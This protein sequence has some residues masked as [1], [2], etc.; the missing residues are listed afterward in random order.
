[1][2]AFVTAELTPEALDR[3]KVIC[4]G[5]VEVESW[6]ETKNLYFDEDQLI[7]RLKGIDIFICEG[8][9]VKT[10]VIEESTSLKIIGSTRDDPN[11]IAVDAATAKH[12]PVIFA[13]KRNTIS[14]AELAVSM[15]LIMARHLQDADRYIHSPDYKVDEFPDFVSNLNRFKGV[16]LN[17]KT[18]GI[19]GLGA[20]GFEVAKRLMAFNVKFL[21]SDPYLS[22]DKLKAINGTAVPLNELMHESDFITLHVPPI[23][24]TDGLISRDMINLM[25]P[26]AYFFNLAR[27]SAIDEDALL[28]ALKEGRIAGA[29]LDVF[30]AEP[31]DRDNPFLQLPNVFATP[32]LGGDTEDTNRR[33][34]AMMVDAIEKI[35]KGEVPKNIMN[36][37]AMGKGGGEK[38]KQQATIFELR[39]QLMDACKKMVAKEFVVNKAGNISCRV[40]TDDGTERYLI[41]PSTLDYSEMVPSDMVLMDGE[42]N[43]IEGSR[44]PSSEK[45]M[46]AR[47]YQARPDINAIVHSH[48]TY[49]TVL[50]IAKIPLLPIADEVLTFIGGCNVADY[51]E[52]G[53]EELAKNA[54]KALGGNYA[55]FIA[56]HGNVCA[57]TSL[58]HAWKNCLLVEY[59]ARIQY[60]A[61]LLDPIY[62]LPEDAEAHEQE[63]YEI[64]RETLGK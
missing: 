7:E 57:G 62:G 38:P 19:V 13:P 24:E 53:T 14:V 34:G 45:I 55:C 47:I 63:I 46:H 21:V 27:T 16:E 44:N 8:D 40:P 10:R 5:N 35:L 15:M 56:N 37:E 42:G 41:T 58:E 29:G 6:R 20:I 32:H 54:V 26:T 61:S 3:L 22:N 12:I 30:S 17:G 64:M 51:G 52:A 28:D 39:Q 60:H 49:S 25:K 1:M 50:S 31:L 43:V 18:V 4:G 11:N 23:D 36:P 59:T 2:K 48:A 33:H 9:N